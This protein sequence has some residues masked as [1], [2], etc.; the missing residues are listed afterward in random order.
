MMVAV[1]AVPEAVNGADPTSVSFARKLTVPDGGTLPA[2]FTVA[3]NCTEV[4]KSTVVGEAVKV[5]AVSVPWV[6]SVTNLKELG[7]VNK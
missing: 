6:H 1:A 3:T 5:V 2:P 7:V 4:V